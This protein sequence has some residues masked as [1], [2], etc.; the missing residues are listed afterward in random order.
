MNPEHFD[1]MLASSVGQTM[2]SIAGG[3]LVTG[4]LVMRWMV[5]ARP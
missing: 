1:P 2:L 5:N 3:L 4:I